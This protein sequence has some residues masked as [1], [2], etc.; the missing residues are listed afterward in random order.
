MLQMPAPP[1]P[2]PP[3]KKTNLLYRK[4]PNNVCRCLTPSEV[5][6]KPPV[7]LIFS[8]NFIGVLSTYNVLLVSGV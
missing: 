2:R 5:E 8:F 3:A 6:H 7:L 4:I 1:Q